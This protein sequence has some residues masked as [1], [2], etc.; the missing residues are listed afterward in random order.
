MADLRFNVRYQKPA[1]WTYTFVCSG[2]SIRGG[3]TIWLDDAE[4]KEILIYGRQNDF[5]LIEK[6]K[7]DKLKAIRVKPIGEEKSKKKTS[8]CGC[9]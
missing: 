5:S 9:G 2:R 4:Y 3:K 1:H 7:K 6:K 8:G